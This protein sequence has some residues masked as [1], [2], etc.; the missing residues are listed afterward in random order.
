MKKQLIV[1]AALGILVTA[2][3]CRKKHKTET[4]YEETV[5]VEE[6]YERVSGPSGWDLEEADFNK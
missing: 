1:L 6:N 3:A 2:P 4:I 5:S